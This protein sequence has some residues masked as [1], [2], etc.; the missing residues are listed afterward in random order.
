MLSSEYARKFIVRQ[1][2]NVSE[3]ATIKA[4][5]CDTEILLAFF[6][7]GRTLRAIVDLAGAVVDLLVQ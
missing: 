1:S 6:A 3:P 7:P 2:I 5:Q 4:H